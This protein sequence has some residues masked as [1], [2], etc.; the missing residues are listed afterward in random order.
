MSTAGTIDRSA[1]EKYSKEMP[2]AHL[3]A[4]GQFWTPDWIARTMATYVMNNGARRVFDPAVGAGGLLLAA[5]NV[6]PRRRITVAGFEVYA[7]VLELAKKEG[8]TDR[9]ASNI[10]V[11]NYLTTSSLPD[12]DA[13]ICNPPY[14]RHHRIEPTIKVKLK[15]DLELWL[16]T[17]LDGR[18]GLHAYFLLRS[19]QRLRRGGRLA[20]ITSADL[21]EG[22]SSVGMWTA[23]SSKFRIDGIV[24]FE[25][26]AT[27][28]PGVDTNPVIC[29]IANEP[30]DDS[31]VYLRVLRTQ[32]RS[33][34]RVVVHVRSREGWR[35][36]DVRRDRRPLREFLPIGLARPRSIPADRTVPLGSLVKCLRGI[37]TGANNFFFLN[38]TEVEKWHLPKD[39]FVRAVGRTRDIQGN[40]LTRADLV[41]LEKRGRPTWL[42]SL[43]GARPEDLPGVVH[44]YLGEGSRLGLPERPL[45][46]Q[47]R[48]WYWI[49]ERKLAVFLFAYLGRRSVRFIRNLANCQALTGFLYVYPR[50]ELSSGIALEALWKC[51][52]HPD[53]LSH[54]DLVAKTYGGGALKVEPRAL[55]RAPIPLSV[56]QPLARFIDINNLNTIRETQLE[57]EHL[58]AASGRP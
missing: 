47:K 37:A 48:V 55:E 4:Y 23:I 24:T 58:V 32:A 54:L 29:L 40:T 15:H 26:N 11:G 51:M 1:A 39:L 12:E 38:E 7:E 19:L 6:H 14:I 18:L 33:L 35:D 46:R 31:Y 20:Y 13:V 49:E 8:L 41:Q 27:P 44:T 16:G 10:K 34:E 45:L 25:E 2:R 3:Q 52:N 28:F 43:R 22:A 53:F 30:P 17:K 36:S 42:L 21:Y 5:K 9:D 57:S 56:L 50:P